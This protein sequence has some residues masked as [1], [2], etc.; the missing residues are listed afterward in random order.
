[1]KQV[2]LGKFIE[3]QPKLRPLFILILIFC[4]C[5]AGQA[6]RIEKVVSDYCL[7]DSGEEAGGAGDVVEV[8]RL[9]RDQI[10]KVAIIRIIK[11]ERGK[12]A[13]KVVKRFGTLKL[14]VGDYLYPFLIEKK[15]LIRRYVSSD[16]DGRG[17]P[18]FDLLYLIL[19]AR[20]IKELSKEEYQYFLQKYNECREYR[21]VKSD[22]GPIKKT[23]RDMIK[24]N[25]RHRRWVVAGGVLGILL[26]GF[27]AQSN[28]F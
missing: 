25:E 18:C 16:S 11:S 13:A 3:E 27:A 28:S 12:T 24:N 19:K 21:Q 6:Q 26:T 23:I 15:E 22:I 1:M 20:P 9:E 10:V 17:N 7:I 8:A 5:I 14:Q 2:A 4:F